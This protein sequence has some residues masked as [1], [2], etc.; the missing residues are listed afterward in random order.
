[1][2]Q[3]RPAPA[4][5]AEWLSDLK[6]RIRQTQQRAA[7]AA[8]AE[9]ILLYWRIGSDILNRQREQGWGARI[10]DR[11]AA[12]LRAEFPDQKGFSPRNLR[13]MRDFAAAWTDPGILQQVVARLPWGHNVRLL[14]AVRQPDRRLWYAR[15]ALENGWSR[16]VLAL[17]I[18]TGLHARQGAAVT[19]FSQTLPAGESDLA[20]QLVKDPYVFDFLTLTP[21]AHERQLE[22]ALVEHLKTFLIELGI[23]FAFVGSQYPL[24]VGGQDYCLDLLF[25]HLKLRRYVVIDLKM[26]EFAP[27]YAGKMQF[28]LTALDDLKREPYMEPSIGLIL[29]K[30]RNRV[31]VE[32]ALRDIAKPIGVSSYTVRVTETL[33]SDLAGELP[34]AEQFERILHTNADETT[35]RGGD[36]Q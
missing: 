33:P 32:Y 26:D 8:N 12:D 11:L 20:R 1:M 34:T 25:F 6:D 14:E 10:V 22:A 13:Y 30:S 5:Y 9:L 16:S 27:E 29:C 24:E 36:A 15:A 23:G 18:E 35:T 4:G 17:Q 7:L 3:H 21:R 2:V 31:V 28:Y 19:N